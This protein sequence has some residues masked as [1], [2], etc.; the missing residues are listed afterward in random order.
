MSDA[1][2]RHRVAAPKVIHETLDQETVV[3]NLDTGAYYSLDPVGCMIWQAFAAGA[4]AEEAA[5]WICGQFDGDPATVLDECRRL[6]GEFLAE[7][8]MVPSSGPPLPL[9]TPET[10]NRSPFSIPH[11]TRYTDMQDLLLLDPVHEVDLAAGWPMAK[12]PQ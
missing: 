6:A 7:G 9:P 5:S 12:P 1:P 3:V 2:C 11:L 10:G 4:T 8:L